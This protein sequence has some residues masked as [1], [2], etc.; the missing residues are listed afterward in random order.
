MVAVHPKEEEFKQHNRK[1]WQDTE[2]LNKKLQ[3]DF[4]SRSLALV[5]HWNVNL[6]VPVSTAEAG[7][8]ENLNM[9]FSLTRNKK[10]N[11]IG[12]AHV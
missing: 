5:M 1:Q 4:A 12:R 8:Q 2:D 9:Q 11:K 10:Q 6:T 3:D 7:I